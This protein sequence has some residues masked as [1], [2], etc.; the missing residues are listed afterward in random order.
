MAYLWGMDRLLL[1]MLC[2]LLFLI[3]HVHER[4]I[5]KKNIS[6][7]ISDLL[8][9]NSLSFTAEAHRSPLK[10]LDPHFHLNSPDLPGA[11]QQSHWAPSPRTSDAISQEWVWASGMLKLPQ[12]TKCSRLKPWACSFPKPTPSPPR[13]RP[14]RPDLCRFPSPTPRELGNMPQR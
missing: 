2:L 8:S 7:A 3:T 4:I 9:V 12:V 6:G 13:S 5:K 1:Y 10:A 14:P 11:T